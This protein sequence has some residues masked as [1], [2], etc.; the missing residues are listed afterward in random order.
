MLQPKGRGM[1]QGLSCKDGELAKAI[2]TRCFEQGLVIETS[3]AYDQVVKC[4]CPLTITDDELN[5]ALDI[6]E[7]S[8]KDI[9]TKRY[10]KAS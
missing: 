3:G 5:K 9:I 6:I 1:M 10:S 4:L 2:I 7:Q 8:V